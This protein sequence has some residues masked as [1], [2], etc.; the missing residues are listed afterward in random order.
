VRAR[1]KEYESAVKC[2]KEWIQFA[3]NNTSFRNDTLAND[4][5]HIYDVATCRL[6]CRITS[7]VQLFVLVRFRTWIV[8]F[9]SALGTVCTISA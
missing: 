6:P 8:A 2:D 1:E 5:V 3:K 7:R 9:L 4:I